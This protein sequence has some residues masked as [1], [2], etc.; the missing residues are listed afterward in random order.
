MLTNLFRNLNVTDKPQR[1]AAKRLPF[2]AGM[3]VIGSTAFVAKSTNA[4]ADVVADMQKCQQTISR[5]NAD[6]QY[7]NAID[8]YKQKNYS[9]AI[10]DLNASS[11]A[12]NTSAPGMLGFMYERGKGV[13]ADPARGVAYYKQGANL[14]NADAMH[15]LG[16]CYRNG[17]GV[18]VNEPEAQRWFK[19]AEAHGTQEGP[20]P[21]PNHR[22]EP[23][24][25]DFD[26]GVK[27]Y[28]A[29]NYSQAFTTFQRAANAGNS[30]AELQIGNQYEVGEGIAKNLV[31]AVRWYT[32]SANA[33]NSIAQKNIGYMYENALGTAENWPLAAQW[34][35]KS[36][37]QGYHEGEFALG[38]CYEFGIG[39]A[40]D[41]KEAIRWFTYAR[42]ERQPQR[43]LFRALA[44]RTHQLH[45]L[46]QRRRKQ[47]RH[48]PPPLCGRLPGRRSNRPNLQQLD[49]AH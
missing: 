21:L 47:I 11:A 38:R 45:R 1:R 49:R 44:R 20:E 18:P 42:R 2:L 4:H 28:K 12:G 24:Q 39:V 3:I 43:S 13:P 10:A 15:E 27:L 36:A 17:I 7:C 22:V 35:Q 31:E 30:A 29:K 25:A 19:Q 8:A 23:D 40:Q 41:R 46:P 14:G 6:Q 26:A 32:K 34:Y 33:G 9:Q 16:R 5:S 37:N 48:G